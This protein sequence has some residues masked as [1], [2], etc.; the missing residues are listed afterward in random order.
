VSRAVQELR[1]SYVELASG[2]YVLLHFP[3]DRKAATLEKLTPAEEQ[4]AWALLAGF[5]NAEIALLR[6]SSSRTVANQVAS[7]FRKLKVRSRSEMAAQ[8]T[9]SGRQHV[10]P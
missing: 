5:S 3:L 2:A 9:E 10:E 6:G 1:A 8:W 4:V 7:L